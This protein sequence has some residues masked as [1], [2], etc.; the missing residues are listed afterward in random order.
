[1]RPIKDNQRL[2]GNYFESPRPTGGSESQAHLFVRHGERR[3]SQ[4]QSSEG[5]SRVVVLDAATEAKLEIIH[6]PS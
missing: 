1:M 4:F 5:E 6:L 2:L 3:A